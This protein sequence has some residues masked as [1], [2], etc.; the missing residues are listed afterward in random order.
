[1]ENKEN[2]LFSKSQK[3]S[4]CRFHCCPSSECRGCSENPSEAFLNGKKLGRSELP[5]GGKVFAGTFAKGTEAFLN[6]SKLGR[7]E[8]PGGGKVFCR[9]FF[10]NHSE[11]CLNGSKLGRSELPGGGKVFCRDFCENR[12]TPGW[13]T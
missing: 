8:L 1:M 6:G 11:A 5:G 3:A 13:G 12:S 9:D 4:R 7:S 10:E 2:I